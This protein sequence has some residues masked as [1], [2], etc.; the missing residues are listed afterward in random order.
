[1]IPVADLDKM[2]VRPAVERRRRVAC[3][4]IVQQPSTDDATRHERMTCLVACL[5]YFR[6]VASCFWMSTGKWLVSLQTNKDALQQHRATPSSTK[7]D[8]VKGVKGLWPRMYKDLGRL[9]QQGMVERDAEGEH[10]EEKE[11]R[12]DSQGL[13]ASLVHN[14]F[15][16]GRNTLDEHDQAVAPPIVPH[17]GTSACTAPWHTGD[18]DIVDKVATDSAKSTTQLIDMRRT[19]NACQH[20]TWLSMGCWA[21]LSH[22][23]R[24]A[25][26]VHTMDGDTPQHPHEAA[27]AYHTTLRVFAEQCAGE[28]AVLIP[29]F[30]EHFISSLQTTMLAACL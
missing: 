4:A 23:L 21:V 20:L 15:R 3:P 2:K 12:L 29:A 26:G 13:I 22:V 14:L 27:S 7:Q 6:V 1:M 28:H 8:D 30:A 25:A 9:L 24:A 19:F 10:D 5:R 16:E 11:E 18:A 17:D